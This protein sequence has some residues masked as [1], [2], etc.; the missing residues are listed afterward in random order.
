M[1]IF[2]NIYLD[3][4]FL[5]SVPFRPEKTTANWSIDKIFWPQHQWQWS[6]RETKRC[7]V[8]KWAKKEQILF[9][10]SSISHWYLVLGGWI[11]IGKWPIDHCDHCGNWRTGQ[12]PTGHWTLRALLQPLNS[13]TRQAFMTSPLYWSWPVHCL[14]LDNFFP[15]RAFSTFG[16]D[17]RLANPKPSSRNWNKTTDTHF[18]CEMQ[19]S[20][21][22]SK[23]LNRGNLT[24]TKWEYF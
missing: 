7:R 9:T 2:L 17:Q 3:A 20:N 15:K 24:N 11:S 22:Y 13:N 14:C 4:V 19:V 18:T 16:A 6:P 10:Q 1:S 12:W 23:W 8:A 5:A 21:Q